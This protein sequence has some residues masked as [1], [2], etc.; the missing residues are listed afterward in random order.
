MLGMVEAGATKVLKEDLEDLGAGR[1]GFSS[2]EV[3]DLIV[4][5]I[6]TL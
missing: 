6:N 1:M 5:T 4:E 3:G 2:S